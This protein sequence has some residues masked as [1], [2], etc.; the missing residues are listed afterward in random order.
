MKTLLSALLSAAALLCAAGCREEPISRVIIF[1]GGNLIADISDPGKLATMEKLLKDRER[2][3]IPLGHR[4]TY[5]VMTADSTNFKR[6][7]YNADGY[8]NLLTVEKN[9]ESYRLRNPGEFN[10]LVGIVR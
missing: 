4:F 2:A 7:D 3:D 10:K 8:F 6:W 1:K 5:L 9:P